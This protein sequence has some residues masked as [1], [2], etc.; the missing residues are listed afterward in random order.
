MSARDAP[1]S[2]S[3]PTSETSESLGLGMA[4]VSKSYD[5]NGEATG[6]S[7]CGTSP[8]P[9]SSDTPGATDIVNGTSEGSKGETAK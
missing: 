2:T 9:S 7:S 8:G 6:A 5:Y 4:D 3:S 1:I